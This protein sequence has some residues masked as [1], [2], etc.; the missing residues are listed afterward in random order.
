MK[1]KIEFAP[2]SDYYVIAVK[3]KT[4]D[5]LKEAFTL[6]EIAADILRLFYKGK[7]PKII[8]AEIAK[9]YDAPLEIVTK[10]VAKFEDQIRQKGMI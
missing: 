4:T 1:Y 6:N 7:N 5:E 10:D 3:D 9:K 8:A 2:L